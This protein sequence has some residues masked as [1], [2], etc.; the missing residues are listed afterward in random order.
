[1]KIRIYSLY[2]FAHLKFP[3]EYSLLYFNGNSWWRHKFIMRILFDLNMISI[4]MLSGV[5][6]SRN[7]GTLNALFLCTRAN[8]ASGLRAAAS[9][10]ANEGVSVK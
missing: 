9:Y 10:H 2:F 4:L 8:Y 7:N 1:M 3:W 5:L 6:A